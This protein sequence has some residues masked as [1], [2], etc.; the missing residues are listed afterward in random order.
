MGV[1][2]CLKAVDIEHLATAVES[3]GWAGDVRWGRSAALRAL[4]ELGRAPAVGATAQLGLHL[5]G[6]TLWCGHGSCS[7]F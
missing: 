7:K 4:V 5:G 3:A 6:S 1:R 2:F